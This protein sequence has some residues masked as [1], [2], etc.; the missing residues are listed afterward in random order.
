MTEPNS[1]NRH[2]GGGPHR[3]LR[4]FVR[5]ALPRAERD[6][7]IHE[8]DDLF[9]RRAERAGRLG[10]SLW[11]LR[12][13]L[14]FRTRLTAEG[15]RIM[16]THAFE[17]VRQFATESRRAAR[18]LLRAPMYLAVTALT[19]GIGVG[20]VVTVYGIADW[21]LLR[22]VPGVN[23]PGR[24]A[25]LRLEN[26]DA[27]GEFS[28]SHSDVDLRTMEEMMPSVQALS[29]SRAWDIHLR[30]DGGA[31]A[32]RLL[33]ELTTPNYFSVL[34][35]T[36]HVGRFFVEAEHRGTTGPA[37]VVVSYDLWRTRWNANPNAVGSRVWVNGHPFTVVGVAPR[38][39]RGAEL[40]GGAR[41]W[42]PPTAIRALF[43]A[44]GLEYFN[45]PR[46]G[47]WS[48]TVGRM[49]TGAT[50]AQ[51][52]QEAN[53]AMRFVRD[54]S[55]RRHSFSRPNQAFSAY[56]GIGLSPWIRPD[57]ERTLRILATAT[58]LL[59]LL[60]VCNVAT[61]SLARAAADR[62]DIA[63]RRALGAARYQV[64]QIPLAEGGL[65]GAVAGASAWGIASLAV[66]AFDH[67]SLSSLGASLEGVRLAPSLI[68][69]CVG[70]AV[71]AGVVAGAFPG[72]WSAA[73]SINGVLRGHGTGQAEATR[74]R[75][76]FVV[77]QVALSLVLTIG[78][79]LAI[80]TVT[81]LRNVDLGVES[82]NRLT[83]SLD[84]AVNG[85]SPDSITSLIADLERAL[86]ADPRVSSV[87]F[88]SPT[89]F[90]ARGRINNF[91]PANAP[92]E[93]A[94]TLYF[95][96]VS[97]GFFETLG[98]PIIYGRGFRPNDPMP[99]V[100]V[101]LSA[102]RQLFPDVDP[103]DA[104]GRTVRWSGGTG[105]IIGVCADA[106]M[107]DVKLVPYPVA[108][109]AWKDFKPTQAMT[110]YLAAA[111]GIRAEALGTLARTALAQ[112]DPELPIYDERTGEDLVA[113]RFAENRVVA[114]LAS[115]LAAIGLFLCALGLFG[116]LSYTVTA[117]AREFGIKIALGA[118]A[119]HIIRKVIG[120][121]LRLT[122]A[123]LAV[124]V[125]A[126]WALAR[127]ASAQLYGITATD[128]VTYVG[129]AATL[130]LVGLAAGALPV[131]R[132]T[133]VSPVD[134]LREE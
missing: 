129:G 3:W 49:T 117:R 78:G 89:S 57:V 63:V 8:L 18:R 105:P 113:T 131:R 58:G 71:V 26:E 11:Y 6:L 114:R 7:L 41:A 37:E 93:E 90:A 4:R 59:L 130:V 47:V 53:A 40:P 61:L 25:W 72:W 83:W 73:R 50:I 42:L 118:D 99:G 108:F 28:W 122:L 119:T 2:T 55:G 126:A 34:A 128:P 16:G 91:R 45:D 124:G 111:P 79:G 96:S 94:V 56:A 112:L 24:L 9:V 110:A 14:S 27:P 70:L 5:F 116:V 66:R 51:V 75:N 1:R 127:L 39:F 31:G 92:E 115:V 35:M 62:T 125:P 30:L 97:S 10:A 86:V 100:V 23:E 46:A 80:R 19:L 48:R 98:V 76:V 82:A 87:A 132:A 21:V 60:A 52:Q 74:L 77:A 32:E 134:V 106:Q 95:F 20:G 22:E 68:L 29:G 84:P 101:S 36:P 12:Q 15:S 104:V 13:P 44:R 43:P 38:G 109:F 123:G 65:V 88:L 103:A 120:D 81:N 54:E 85:Y 133:S 69:G 102:A 64:L 33:A 107:V 17:R 67:S 121:G